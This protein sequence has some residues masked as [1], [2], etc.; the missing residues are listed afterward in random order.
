[1]Y[2][3][4][5]FSTN[6]VTNK[7]NQFR[8]APNWSKSAPNRFESTRS[9]PNIAPNYFKSIPMSMPMSRPMPMSIIF[10]R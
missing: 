3:R 2:V 8:S 9:W 1:M 6:S 7:P 4:S 5:Y 10:E